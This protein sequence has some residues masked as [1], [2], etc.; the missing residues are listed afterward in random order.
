MFCD[1][2]LWMAGGGWPDTEEGARRF[3]GRARGGF[4]LLEVMVVLMIIGLMAGLVTVFAT[5]A[6]KGAKRDT[7][8][9]QIAQ[10]ANVI[11]LFYLENGRYP[12]NEEGLEILLEKSKKSG[13]PLMQK[14][15]PDPW[16]EKYG[17]N[18][19]AAD[20]KDF[21]IFTLGADKQPGGEDDDADLT[22]WDLEAG[23]KDA[24]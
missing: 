14:V 5:G 11:D 23:D 4:S 3:H 20:G 13:E 19:P 22:N 2:G 10:I 24:P 1:F 16:G 17:Y 18:S 9:A 8:A 7:A 15:P 21:E 6:L 12:T